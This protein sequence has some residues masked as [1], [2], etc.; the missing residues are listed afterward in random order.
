M[1][2]TFKE[3]SKIYILGVKTGY[4]L[5]TEHFM[6]CFS[7]KCSQIYILLFK[8]RYLKILRFIIKGEDLVYALMSSRAYAVKNQTTLPEMFRSTAH[9][10]LYATQIN[11]RELIPSY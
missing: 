10:I 2:L 7:R 3:T 6:F 8:T 9:H 4:F 1:N 5:N 11:T